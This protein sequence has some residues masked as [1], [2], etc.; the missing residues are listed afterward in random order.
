[1]VNAQNKGDLEAEFAKKTAQNDSLSK[2]LNNYQIIYKYASD[3]LVKRDFYPACF[4]IIMGSIR[5][6]TSG[7]KNRSE[8]IEGSSGQ[9]FCVKLKSGL[10]G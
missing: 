3:S 5:C 7:S 10:G 9:Y 1:M 4:G 6:R 2:Q 8:P